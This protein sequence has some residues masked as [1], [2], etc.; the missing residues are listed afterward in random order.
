MYRN[1]MGLAV[2][3]Q[4]SGG[5]ASSS[6]QSSA[7]ETVVVDSEPRQLLKR[8]SYMDDSVAV[9]IDQSTRGRARSAEPGIARSRSKDRKKNAGT[10][11]SSKEPSL[12]T[13]G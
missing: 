9:E 12:A 5:N 13:S 1:S 10:N 3:A 8:D 7:V 6:Q 4:A 2:Q 11:F